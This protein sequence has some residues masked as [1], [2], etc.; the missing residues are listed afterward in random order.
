LQATFLGTGTS[1]GIP[2]IGCRCSVCTSSDPHNQRTRC[3]LVVRT[4]QATVLVDAATELRLQAVREGL[5]RVDAVLFTHPHADHVG[6][7]DDLRRFNEIQ[8]GALPCYANRFTL[9]EIRE[10]YGYIFRETQLGGGKP[11]LDLYE[12]DGL[13]PLGGLPVQPVPVWHGRLPILGYRLGDLAYIT[14]CSQMPDESLALLEGVKVLIIGALRWRP[15][16]THFNL[17]QAME[18]AQRLAPART[19]FTH[20]CHDLDH[21]ATNARLPDG[22]E[23]AYD[24]LMIEW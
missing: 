15:H 6:G 20:I 12:V 14:D 19:Y 17:D 16:P 11:H 2:V 8:G 1:H 21:E 7:L 22:I 13:F 9:D 5:D 24:G 23:L 4:S 3:S 10:R 18:V